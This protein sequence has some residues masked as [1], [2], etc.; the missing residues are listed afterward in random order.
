MVETEGV[1]RL[2]REHEALELTGPA[3]D[4]EGATIEDRAEASSTE[5]D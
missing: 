4:T 5:A 3:E 1:P 2:D